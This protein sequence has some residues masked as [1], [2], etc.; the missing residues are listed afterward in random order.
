MMRVWGQGERHSVFRRVPVGLLLACLGATSAVAQTCTTRGVETA[1][2]NSHQK[3]GAWCAEGEFLVAFDLDGPRNYAPHDSPVVRQALCCRAGTTWWDPRW[4]GVW[5]AQ[6]NS[7]QPGDQW[8]PDGKFIIALDLDGP[9]NLD[10]HDSPV[11]G[12]AF[13]AGIEGHTGW[14]SRFWQGVE[15]AGINSHQPSGSWCPAGA[16]LVS[17][18]QDSRRDYAAYDSPVIGQAQCASPR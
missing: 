17:F 3:Q 11:V 1:G 8:C 16:Y 6:K 12:A 2:I 10:P 13:C 15:S 9:R 18:D 7:H 4:E 14:G 5:Q